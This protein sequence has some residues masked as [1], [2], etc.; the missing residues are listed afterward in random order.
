MDG[1]ELEALRHVEVLEG[2]VAASGGN[3]RRVVR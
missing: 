2:I 1:M 3:P